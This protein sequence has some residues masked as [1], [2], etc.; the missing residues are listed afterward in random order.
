MKDYYQN[1]H[2]LSLITRYWKKGEEPAFEDCAKVLTLAKTI[3][4][5]TA[6]QAM[7]HPKGDDRRA[8][9][10]MHRMAAR[11]EEMARSRLGSASIYPTPG[12]V[13]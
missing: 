5:Q 4:R 10:K 13:A 7:R 3:R 12:G 11:L 8:F 2:A 6:E 1:A 9:I